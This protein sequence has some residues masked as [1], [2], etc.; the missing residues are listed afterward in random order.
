MR[1]LLFA[2]L[3]FTSLAVSAAPT[4]SFCKSY[5]AYQAG[6]SPQEICE[7]GGGSLCG[8]YKQAGH[9]LCAGTGSTM[10]EVGKNEGQA[11][12]HALGGSFCGPVKTFAEGLCVGRGD[13]NCN[14]MSSGEQKALL[15][16]VKAECE[17]V[18]KNL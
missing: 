11:V 4:E 8:K 18:L 1:S 3:L 15:R 5:E 2:I 16:K 13:H 6:D 10:C 12:C 7:A 17:E 14:K 9:A